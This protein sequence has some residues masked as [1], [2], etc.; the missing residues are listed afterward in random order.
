LLKRIALTKVPQELK[1][2]HVS[3]QVHFIDATKHPQI[4]LEAGEQ[5]LGS[6]LMH[7][8]ARIVLLGVGAREHHA[9]HLRTMQISAHT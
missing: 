2:A 9:P 3:W 1:K 7:V 5:T 8:T 4:G 6:L